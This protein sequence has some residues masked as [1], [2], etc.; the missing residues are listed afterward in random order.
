MQQLMQQLTIR[1]I[2]FYFILFYFILF[3]FI[4]FYFI[5]FYFILFYFI[6]FYF[7]LFCFVLFCFVLI[8]CFLLLRSDCVYLSFAGL[9]F[10]STSPPSLFPSKIPQ[11]S[12]CP[13]KTPQLCIKA[14]QIIFHSLLHAHDI[15]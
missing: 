8:Y 6:L 3:Y 14:H 15:A 4:L 2:L 7:I 5:L 9:V 10:A 11:L 12:L 1:I 13:S